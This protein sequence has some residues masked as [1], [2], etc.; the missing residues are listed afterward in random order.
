MKKLLLTLSILALPLLAFG[1]IRQVGWD[2]PTTYDDGTP[3]APAE[4]AFYRVAWGTVKG[5]PYPNVVDTQDNNTMLSLD[6]PA[7]N[8]IYLVARTVGTNGMESDNSA[9]LSINLRKPAPP[10]NFYLQ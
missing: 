2:A 5:G 1:I 3:L 8:R 6:F 4:I 10:Q 7:N 9:E